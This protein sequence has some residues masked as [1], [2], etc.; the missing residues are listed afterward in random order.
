MN[1]SLEKISAQSS[2][3]PS[4]PL[5]K[6]MSVSFDAGTFTLLAGPTGAGKSTLLDIIGGLRPPDEGCILYGDNPLWVKSRISYP[7]GRDAVAMVFQYPEHQLFARTVRGEFVYSLKPHHLPREEQE[8]RIGKAMKHMDLPLELLERSPF[9]LSGGQKRRVALA[10]ALAVEPRWLLLDE[11]GAGLDPEGIQFLSEYLKSFT[12]AGGSVILA[13]HD[14]DAFLPLADKIVLLSGGRITAA[15][16]KEELC[17]R[18]QLLEES[19]LAQ[20]DSLQT[21]QELR[22]LGWKLPDWLLAPEEL[23]AE[24]APLLLAERPTAGEARE[25]AAAASE[26]ASQAAASS[27]PA[28]E[29]A[30]ALDMSPLE[31]APFLASAAAPASTFAPGAPVARLDADPPASSLKR[32]SASGIRRSLA[33]ADPRALWIGYILLSAG[34]LLSGSLPALLASFAV[35]A[36]VVAMSPIA[37]RMLWRSIKP[38][39]LLLAASTLLSGLQFSGGADE[40]SFLSGITF[41]EEAALATI[42]RLARLLCVLCLGILLPLLASPIRMKRGL[43][44]GLALLGRLKLPVEALAL[45]ASLVL[46]FVPLILSELERFSR[47][48]RSRGKSRAKPGRFRPRDLPVI[49]IPLVGSLIRSAEEFANTME[50]R[51]YTR[52]GQSR[53]FGTTLR[54]NRKDGAIIAASTALFFV[55]FAI[56]H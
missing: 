11:P 15:V 2:Q 40:P 44:Q 45:A 14:L 26:A 4:R 24:L 19:E 43:E 1:I 53:T 10:A 33:G 23:A 13:A 18:P 32:G 9:S 8:R 12:A 42:L 52:I 47:I 35:T 50:M 21:A 56:G 27:M 20:P 39:L 30:A 16:S 34:M 54:M 48:A 7:Q 28:P 31:P 6:D 17:R 5:L 41:S 3:E 55:L 51:G 38:F 29:P 49:L 25:R 36:A 37:P 46:R 22:R